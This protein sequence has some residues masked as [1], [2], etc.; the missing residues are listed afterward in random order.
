[1]NFPK[2]WQASWHRQ[3]ITP[4]VCVCVFFSRI[5]PWSTKKSHRSS[6]KIGLFFGIEKNPCYA[7]VFSR[8][9][10]PVGKIVGGSPRWIEGFLHQ[11]SDVCFP[12]CFPYFKYFRIETGH[13]VAGGSQYVGNSSCF[14][15]VTWPSEA[16]VGF[17]QTSHGQ[18]EKT[19][20]ACSVREGGKLSPKKVTQLWM[21]FFWRIENGFAPKLLNIVAEKFLLG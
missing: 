11:Y 1:M 9:E 18:P 16:T 20:A 19:T 15:Q 21:I 8:H 17:V 5:S 7:D 13:G 2:M 4:A 3:K 14:T 6:L 10:N 12:Y